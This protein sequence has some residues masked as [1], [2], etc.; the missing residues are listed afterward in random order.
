MGIAITYN[1]IQ[2]ECIRTFFKLSA[3]PLKGLENAAAAGSMELMSA[4]ED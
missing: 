3:D 1:I 4:A 2:M